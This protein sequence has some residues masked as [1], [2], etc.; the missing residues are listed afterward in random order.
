M[1]NY[2]RVVITGIGGVCPLGNT[3]DEIWPRLLNGESSV[4]DLTS[5]RDDKGELKYPWINDLKTHFGSLFSDYKFPHERIGMDIKDARR[6]APQTQYGIDAASQALEDSGLVKSGKLTLEGEERRGLCERTGVVA[7]VGYGSFVAYD[8][9]VEIQREKGVTRGSPMFIIT[10]IPDAVSGGV[11][12]LYGFHGPT[13]AIATACEAGIE[14]IIY[15]MQQIIL[16]HVDTMVCLGTVESASPRIFAGFDAMRALSTRNSDPTKASRPFDENRDGFVLGEGAGGIVIES[17]E[18]ALKRREKNPSV[19]IYGEIYGYGS[20]SDGTHPTDP[21]PIYQKKA[22]EMALAMANKRAEITSD[23][24]GY[25][26]CHGTSTEKNDLTETQVLREVFG[27]HAFDMLFNS[28]KSMIGHTTPASG[29]LET[30]VLL[31]TLNTGKIHP[32]INCDNP[33]IGSDG[34]SLDYT[35]NVLRERIIR[36]AMKNAFGFF[37]HNGSLIIG[38]NEYCTP[39]FKI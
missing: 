23:M 9:Q 32:T 30:I 22:I 21:N 8:K 2:E 29:V 5:D 20:T 26:N 28:T 35:P 24:I 7:G 31:Q 1:K 10:A 3:I 27:E 38:L 18:H 33:I 37:G 14:A 13:P 11:A 39:S 6:L 16:G 34:R 19:R 4:R 12:N 17:L 25:V 36:F 15:G